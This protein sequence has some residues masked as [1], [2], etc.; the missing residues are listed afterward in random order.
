MTAAYSAHVCGT[1]DREVGMRVIKGVRSGFL[2]TALLAASA[3]V[4]PGQALAQQPKVLRVA[5]HADVRT[6][7]PFWT[8]QTI[9]GIHGMMVYDT[10]F[11]MDHD[12]N[13]RPQM[14]GAWSVSDD[15]KT[16]S[17]TLRDGLKFHDGSPVTTKD[18]IASLNRWGKRDGAGRTLFGY[19]DQIAAKDDKTF[20][21]TLKE[22][23]ALVI[24][25]LAKSGTSIPFVMRE[26]E[27]M[28][29]PMQ[30][31]QEVI[32]SGPFA[33][34]R[35]EWVPGSKTVYVKFA[36]Y[37]PR[38]E[39]ASGH[40]GGKVAKVD[41]VEFVW[42]ADPQTAQA[43]LVAGEIDYLEN[44]A[45]DFLPILESSPGVKLDSHPAMGTM[46]II[47]FNHLHP[48]FNNVKARQAMQYIVN[49]GDYLNTI[50]ADKRLQTPCFSYF[51]CGVPM[52]TDAGAERYKAAKDPRR[53]E[54]LFK[55]AGYNG[56]PIT[57]LHATDHQYINPANLVLIQQLRRAGFLKL[58]VQAMDWGSVVARRAKKE[59]PAQGGWN[60]FITGTSV[61]SSSSPITHVSLG[62]G[63]ERA[64]F[65]W[66]CDQEFEK[67]RQSWAFAPDLA[68]RKKIAVDI[69]KMAHEVVPYISFA[70][71]RNPVAYRADRISGL[72]SVPSVPVMWNIEKK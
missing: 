46:G 17:F 28:V 47:Q 4:G 52:E 31:I 63:C 1:V 3:L 26:K 61:L 37:V 66:P 19:T 62:M 44:P 68:A 38:Q 15:R 32:G 24:D 23:Y 55:E 49:N 59:P 34:K 64:W 30:Q 70:Q 8:T 22:P 16:Y 58:D 18:V 10:L 27:A 21:W 69:S 60:I 7:D 35:D 20:V 13:A 51:G 53:A 5:M 56:E 36:D 33:F 11:S 57:I 42:L 2:A 41:R 40:A 39:P 12:Q 71:W 48:P 43:A 14:V 54:A 67:L 50:A 65:G 25:T 9:A 6:V 72:V 29:D 45:P